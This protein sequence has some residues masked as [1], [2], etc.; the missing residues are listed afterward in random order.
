[1]DNYVDLILDDAEPV[2]RPVRKKIMSLDTLAAEHGLSLWLTTRRDGRVRHVLLDKGFSPTGA[3]HNMDFLGLDPGLLEAVVLSHGHFDH[4]GGLK[5]LLGR[6]KG[7]LDLVA[8]EDA[9]RDRARKLPDGTIINFPPALKAE[10]LERLGARMIPA[11]GPL[12]I[13]GETILISGPVPRRTEFEKGMPG[14]LLKTEEGWTEDE[15][16]D[17]MALIIDLGTR[18]MI[19]ISGCAH[20]G[21]VNT[22]Q[23]AAELTGRD[24]FAAVIGGFHLSGA[25]MAPGGE[26][27]IAGLKKYS[28]GL[29]MPLHCTGWQ[30]AQTIS[31]AFGD[32]F[33]LSSVGSKIVFD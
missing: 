26:P 14:A 20:S 1:M 32:R 10:E 22:L 19:L 4:T 30:S 24:D 16:N 17:D 33:A 13:A 12:T 27:T 3:L 9:F 2:K 15:I 29:V 5:G 28:P 23:W 31:Q 21:I 7:G 11:P 18:G 8:H 6:L 25:T